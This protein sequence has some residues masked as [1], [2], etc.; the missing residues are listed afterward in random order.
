MRARADEKAAPP[1]VVRAASAS[2]LRPLAK[3]LPFGLSELLWSPRG[4]DAAT[5]PGA[6]SPCSRS[7]ATSTCT[8]RQ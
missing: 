4:A 5:T 1:L 8:P 6:A 3:P 7:S 2:A